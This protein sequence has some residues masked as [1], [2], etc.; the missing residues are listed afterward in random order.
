MQ[1]VSPGFIFSRR[2]G[3]PMGFSKAAKTASFSEAAAGISRLFKTPRR[4]LSGISTLTFPL[5]N[6]NSC[7]LKRD[8]SQILSPLKLHYYNL[9]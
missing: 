8:P 1:A 9:T 5:P 7:T 3:L 2:R 6:F 4:C